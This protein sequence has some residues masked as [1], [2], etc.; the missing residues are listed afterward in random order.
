MLKDLTSIVAQFNQNNSEPPSK[1]SKLLPESDS[2]DEID[3]AVGG[4]SATV[5]PMSESSRVG[6]AGTT[7]SKTS[8]AAV[9]AN[10]CNE[11]QQYMSCSFSSMLGQHP[12]QF[13]KECAAQ[14]PCLSVVARSVL[15]IPATQNKVERN[16]SAA[17]NT[18]TDI[19]SS[20]DPEHVN[21]LLLIRSHFRNSK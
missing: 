12:L 8:R 2:N 18:V 11:V 4:A 15:A 17:G 5:R 6:T 21:E 7:A 10:H 16:F 14:F 20:L 1:R 19:R 9:A 3:N 13:W